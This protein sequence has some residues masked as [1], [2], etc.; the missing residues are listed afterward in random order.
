MAREALARVGLDLDPDVRVDRL[1]IAEKQLVEI[2]K[3]LTLDAQV[4]LMDEPSA[5]LTDRELGRLFAIIR[6]LK[7]R[8]VSVLY[9]S[10]RLEE[11]FAIA[12][13][14]TV[15]RDGKVVGTRSMAECKISALSHMMLGRKLAEMFPTRRN[16]TR[17]VLLRVEGLTRPGVFEDISFELREGEILGLAGLVGSGRTEIARAIF[18]ADKAQGRCVLG[19]KA[20]RRPSPVR[21]ELEFDRVSFSYDGET[22]VLRDISLQVA[23]GETL[24]LVGQSGSG[25]TTL[26]KAITGIIKPDAGDIFQ[27][28]RLRLVDDDGR[29]GGFGQGRVASDVVGVSVGEDNHPN[30]S[31]AY[32]VCLHLSQQFIQAGLSV[33]GRSDMARVDNHVPALAESLRKG[34]AV[35]VIIV[36]L[37]D[38]GI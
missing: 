29:S 15:L 25:K 30:T 8:G 19:G 24:A 33:E 17:E 6:D 4:I 34:I 35:A 38:I 32:A 3:A 27:H 13:R 37:P 21:G 28:L 18:G 36:A 9:I 31:P 23:A 11:V 14:V 5:T 26:A 22:P 12:D 2:A 1:S 20:I 16:M 10:H 7:G